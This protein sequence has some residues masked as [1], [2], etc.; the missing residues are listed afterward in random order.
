[1]QSCDKYSLRTFATGAG[2]IGHRAISPYL[3]VHCRPTIAR[4]SIRPITACQRAAFLARFSPI[5]RPIPSPTYNRLS[6]EIIF[7]AFTKKTCS[8]SLAQIRIP[9]KLPIVAAAPAATGRNRPLS[10]TGT[11]KMLSALTQA[12]AAITF[13]LII[14]R[15]SAP[16]L[17]SVAEI[18]AALPF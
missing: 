15:A 12:A 7:F 14:V 1:M 10:R 4:L 6:A 18:F 2:R 5:S 16:N 17:A 9:A 8:Q 13:G 3:P 11:G